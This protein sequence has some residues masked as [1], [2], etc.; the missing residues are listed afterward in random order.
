MQ[1]S[2]TDQKHLSALA[3]IAFFAVYSSLAT[4]Y[5]F[6]PPLLSVLFVLF[7][8]ALEKQNFYH[9][10]LVITALLIFEANYGYMMFS[11]VIYFYFLYKIVMPKIYTNF[12]CTQCIRIAYPV[13]SYL[14]YYLFLL[15]IANIFLLPIP[16]I[17]Y[18]IIYYIVIEFFI[19]SML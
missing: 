17:D 1:R 2:L 4:I 8:T 12:S 16:H 7:L 9:L 18:Y 5:P 15:F 11:S 13:L 6:L 14:G 3:Y 19:V 10:L